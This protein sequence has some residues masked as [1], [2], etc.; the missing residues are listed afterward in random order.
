M[1]NREKRGRRWKRRRSPGVRDDVGKPKGGKK[2]LSEKQIKS[3]FYFF[4]FLFFYFF[5]N[6]N[7]FNWAKF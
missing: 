4:I 3:L 1:K 7:K 6:R 2:L 5:T